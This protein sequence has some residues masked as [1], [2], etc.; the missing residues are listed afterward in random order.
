MKYNYS[1]IIPHKNTPALLLN[2]IKSI[3]NRDDI[4]IIV[5]D[6]NSDGTFVDF[7]NFPGLD[8]PNVEVYL[9]KEGKG[10]GYARNVGLQHAVG[11]WL[12]FADADDFF[13]ENINAVLDEYKDS[14]ADVVFLKNKAVK[15]PSGEPSMRGAE[16]NRRV[17]IAIETGDFTQAVLYSSPW[18]KFFKRAFIESNNIRFNEVRWG[19]DV[20]FMGKVAAC[21]TSF[22]ASGKVIYCITES[23][24][25]I[26]KDPSLA[27]RIV[28]FDQESENVRILRSTKYRNEP[29]VYYWH[30]RTWFNIW[31]MSRWQAIFRIPS[32]IFTSGAK[33]LSEAFKAKFGE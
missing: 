21:A 8:S 9:T 6:D 19:N 25:S 22:E 12:V 7:E 18:Q 16:L 33:F 27:S 11:K 24:N 4:Q 10:A 26:I 17:D 5:I 29:S 14:D 15:I 23:D 28:R 3:P 2:C 32:A 1:F 30:F 20:V 13:S 31:K